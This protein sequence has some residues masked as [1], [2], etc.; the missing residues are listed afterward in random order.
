MNVVCAVNSRVVGLK[1]RRCCVY[2]RLPWV[3]AMYLPVFCADGLTVAE[4]EMCLLRT[5]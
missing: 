3:L 4:I 5:W 1:L 2:A